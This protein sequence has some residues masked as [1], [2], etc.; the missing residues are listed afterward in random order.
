M[1]EHN[2]RVL[3]LL[4]E[5]LDTGKT[6]EEVCSDCPDFLPE[7]R[8]RWQEFRAIDHQFEELL[9]ATPPAF[10]P[11]ASGPSPLA[12]PPAAGLPQ[13][14]GYELQAVLGHGGMGI[15]YKA[16]HIRLNRIVALKMLVAGAYS[17]ARERARFQQEAEA[18][19]GLRHANIV[20]VYDVGEHEGWPFFTMEFVEGGSLAEKLAGVP[21]P[22]REAAALV[23]TLAEAV[24]VAHQAG[25]VH[26]DLKPANILLTADAIP[27]VTDFGLARRLEGGA[28][29]T[30]TGVAVGTPSYMAPEQALGHRQLIGPA[31]DV[32]ALGAILYELLAGRPPFRAETH[33][34]TLLQVT[35]QDPVPPSRLNARVPRDLE[36]ICLKCLC[37]EAEHR[38][39]S[40]TALAEELSRFLAGRPIQARP[41]GPVARLG[42]WCRRN[43]A[44]A[45]ICVVLVMGSTVS[46]WQAVRATRAEQQAQKRLRQI[47]KVNDL[48]TSIFQNLDPREVARDERPLQAILVEKL[49][50]VVEQLEGESIGDP[51]VV[52]AMQEKFGISL[53]N[54][55]EPAKAIV[56]LEKARDTL[57]A[58][59]GDEHPDTLS[60]MHHL[61]QAYGEAGKYDLAISLQKETLALM[62]ERLGPKHVNTVNSMHQLAQYYSNAGK[63]D[64]SLPLQEETL[65]LMKAGHGPDH[66]HTL[67]SMN[68]LALLYQRVGKLNQALPL[69]EE[70]LKLMKAKLGPD[71]P[72]TLSAMNNLGLAYVAA[73]KLDPAVRLHEETLK[74]R[75]VRLGS[76]H[77]LTLT[78]MHNL[79]NAY[80]AAGK[81]D[82]AQPLHEETLRR[83]KATLGPD[84]PDTL[85]SMGSLAF[86]Y[87]RVGRLDQAVSL[88]DETVK[89]MKVALGP[90]HPDTLSAMNNLGVA[91]YKAGKPDLSRQLFEETLKLRQ[92]RLGLDHP[93]TLNTMF[94]L[95]TAYEAA[96]KMD[97]AE[98]L[99]EETLRRRKATLGPDHRDTVLSAK[100]VD[101]YRNLR[102]APER[103]RA[104]LTRL[105]PEHIDTLLARRD[106]GQLYLTTNRLDEAEQIMVE[107]IDGMKTRST[108]DPARVF[109]IE[110]LQKCLTK[111]E[112]TMSDS[113]LTSQCR[114]RVG[115]ALLG[116]RKFAAAEPLLLT[117]YKGMKR[118]EAKIPP[119]AKAR[120]I[121]TVERLV[122]L[123]EATDRKGEASKWRKELQALRSAATAAKQSTP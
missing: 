53:V 57:R 107:I 101:F 3:A 1:R 49:D 74:L 18:V 25:I 98:P 109:T 40:A 8:L 120:L 118:Q 113:W 22:A 5:I 35:S 58:Q 112:Q 30:Q 21:Q 14:P 81:L 31:A 88:H 103:Y 24:Q 51:L 71:H 67:A 117:G 6:P 92:V 91:Y 84:H 89:R 86:L 115:E 110:L 41:L 72:D 66:P 20:H 59:L 105:G 96:G 23:V 9:P 65:A 10:S 77:A 99:L 36:T 85:I 63:L 34:E 7:V 80:Q 16:R 79:A 90:D 52:A 69:Q 76:E 116:L 38:Y 4:E 37:K 121:Q 46:I 48:V 2:P 114:S 108:D 95:A 106:L 12:V 93:D 54:L 119:Q 17:S 45:A 13:I 33:A 94:N 50:K 83:R 19:A 29:V 28:G 44:A 61:A 15:V 97:Q 70:T 104:N 47:E 26:R 82:Q 43:P 55:V 87:Q 68:N 73:G 64:L 42:R 11:L 102:T 60:V 32:Y 27:K 62:K 123:Y 39:D 78:S 122:Q 100:Y 111:R 75:Q 56:L